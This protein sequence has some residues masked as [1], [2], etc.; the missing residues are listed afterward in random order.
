MSDKINPGEGY[1]LLKDGEVIIGKA[2]YLGDDGWT[3][4]EGALGCGCKWS[5]LFLPMRIKITES[6]KTQKPK[7]T[8]MTAKKTTTAKK[9]V[10][11]APVIPDVKALGKLTKDALIQTVILPTAE[12]LN[13]ANLKAFK[14]TEEAKRL[15]AKLKEAGK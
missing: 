15:R 6:P 13:A 5:E 4:M 7:E 9:P 12:A 11:P 1:R 14:A 10:P 3:S 2:E 8:K